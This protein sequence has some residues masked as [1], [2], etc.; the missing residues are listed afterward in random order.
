MPRPFLEQGSNCLGRHCRPR[1]LPSASPASPRLGRT[2]CPAWTGAPW[3]RLAGGRGNFRPSLR[4]PF[5]GHF[6]AVW[7]LKTGLG[8]PEAVRAF[9]AYLCLQRD[10]QN[11]VPFDTR[12]PLRQ[13]GISPPHSAHFRFT[14]RK[15][16]PA[17]S[18]SSSCL[19]CRVRSHSIEQQRSPRESKRVPAMRAVD[20]EAVGPF[21]KLQNLS[22]W[23]GSWGGSPAS[24]AAQQRL[25]Q[26]RP[27][28]RE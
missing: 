23:S 3:H 4:T 7:R 28:A 25:E 20:P 8:L 24:K 6:F 2:R 1:P 18:A 15:G 9:L 10:E 22:R 19:R 26:N 5:S 11:F 17:S 21:G 13:V 14:A 12:R 27:W 16:L